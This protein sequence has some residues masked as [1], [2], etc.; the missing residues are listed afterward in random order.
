MAIN[1][2]LD[3]VKDQEEER[4][5]LTSFFAISTPYAVVNTFAILKWILN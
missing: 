1:K 4:T 5:E 3:A 2:T